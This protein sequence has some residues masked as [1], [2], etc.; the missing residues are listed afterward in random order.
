MAIAGTQDPIFA[1]VCAFAERVDG[2][3]L[4]M[5]GRY[6]V[7]AFLAAADDRDGHGVLHREPG[8]GGSR[9]RPN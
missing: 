9:F 1:A 3:F 5:D 2:R 4:A 8:G 6:N 7:T